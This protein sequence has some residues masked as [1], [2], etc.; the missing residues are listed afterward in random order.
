MNVN[1]ATLLIADEYNRMAETYDRVVAPRIEPIAK[2]VAELIAPKAGEM[3]LDVSTGTGLLA[4][5]LAPR[6][7]PAQFVAIDLAEEALRVASYRAG[8]AGIRNI[9]F[10]MMDARNIVYRSK[11][12]DAVGSN[13]GIPNLGYDR[14]FHEVHRLLKP[15]GRFVFS[16]WDAKLPPATA[17]YLEL[18]EKHRT[19]TPSK[20]LVQLREAIALNRTAPEAK[21][22]R[23]AAA[24]GRKL[25][26]VEFSDVRDVVRTFPAHFTGAA[27]LI[28]FE[29]AWGWDEREL[30]EMTPAQRSALEAELAE[31]VKPWMGPAGLDVTWTVH[32]TI[33]RA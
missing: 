13:L 16:E 15:G 11:L 4:C 18:L 31:R 21:D 2:A 19:T 9:R 23:D 3:I 26:A 32:V 33:A 24:V 1:E 25:E 10:E 28:A 29:T 20:T 14:T 8:T 7:A 12:F 5:L 30:A 17:A 6:T 27:D 22:L